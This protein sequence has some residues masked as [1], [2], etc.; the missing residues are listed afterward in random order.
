MIAV[1]PIGGVGMIAQYLAI[2]AK[3]RQVGYTSLADFSVTSA[4]A[5]SPGIVCTNPN[6]TLYCLDDAG[7]QA[8]FV[9]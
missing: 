3:H 5:V 2:D 7:K 4:E 6:I 8:N 9:E 1:I